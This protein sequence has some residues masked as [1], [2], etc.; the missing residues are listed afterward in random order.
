V[1]KR[2]LHGFSDRNNQYFLDYRTSPILLRMP[3]FGMSNLEKEF[4]PLIVGRRI[5][6]LRSKQGMNLEVLARA[7]ERA[8]SQLK[9]LV[10]H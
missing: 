5:R 9:H 8:P 1:N 7:I 6:E 2:Q 10:C 3:E 4:D